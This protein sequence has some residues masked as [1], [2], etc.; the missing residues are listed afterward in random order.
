MGF[1]PSPN[2]TPRE[3]P[4]VRQEFDDPR[5][6]IIAGGFSQKAVA[7][8]KRCIACAG[9]QQIANTTTMMT[10]MRTTFL[11]TSCQRCF[12]SIR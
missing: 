7:T 6:M 1:F 8:Q 10:S 4:Q 3:I 2:P 5:Y 12:S 11:V 9:S